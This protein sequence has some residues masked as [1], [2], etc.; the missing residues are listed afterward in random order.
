MQA[1]ADR[2]RTALRRGNYKSLLLGGG[3]SVAATSFGYKAFLNDEGVSISDHKAAEAT[4]TFTKTDDFTESDEA[5]SVTNA[6]KKH[7]FI[8]KKLFVILIDLFKAIAHF[9][10]ARAFLGF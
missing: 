4:F 7:E 10:E 8:L 1:V 5:L 9:D 3:V 2:T 6:P